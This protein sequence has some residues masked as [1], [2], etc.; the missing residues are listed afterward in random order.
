M[1]RL[2]TENRE[3]DSVHRRK[4]KPSQALLSPKKRKKSKRKSHSKIDLHKGVENE[5]LFLKV[6]QLLNY[7]SFPKAVVLCGTSLSGKSFLLDFVSQLLNW[8]NP[9]SSVFVLR[10]PVYLMD[11]VFRQIEAHFLEFVAKETN[12]CDLLLSKK[13][14]WVVFE[15]VSSFSEVDKFHLHYS[16]LPSKVK[17]KFWFFFENGLLSSLS[18]SKLERCSLVPVTYDFLP[19][20]SLI[21]F[22]LARLQRLFTFRLKKF[23]VGVHNLLKQ[24]KSIFGSFED[25]HAQEV[26]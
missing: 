12:V 24:V 8:S 23:K 14:L 5:T 7:L 6:R 16:K 19:F 9:D 25:Q 20:R 17:N 10:F 13:S 3:T 26:V 21:R 11:R 4:S 18:P 22:K 1:P 2:S 15:G